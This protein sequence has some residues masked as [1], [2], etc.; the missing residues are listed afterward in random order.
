MSVAPSRADVELAH[1]KHKWLDIGT[2]SVRNLR[3]MN[4]KRRILW[5]LLLISPVPI[6]MLYNSV[7]FR[8]I[9]RLGYGVIFVPNDLSPSESLVEDG[10]AESKFYQ[11]I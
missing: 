9:S 1:Q 4:W 6:H 8:S 11:T 10:V 7:V 2:F 3:A 5:D